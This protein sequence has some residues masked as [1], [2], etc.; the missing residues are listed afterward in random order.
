[1]ETNS[2]FIKAIRNQRLQPEETARLQADLD[3]LAIA[4]KDQKPPDATQ[5]SPV[6]S[7]IFVYSLAG[8]K[9]KNEVEQFI[10]W[11]SHPLEEPHWSQALDLLVNQLF[12]H[13][14]LGR[15]LPLLEKINE[16]KSLTHSEDPSDF[17]SSEQD[18]RLKG[19]YHNTVEHLNIDFSVSVLPFPLE[20]L[21]PRIVTVKPGKGNEL[22]RHA[23]E[24]VF[25]FLRG[26]GMVKVDHLSHPVGPGDFAFIPRW[27]LH[28]SINTGTEDLVFLAVADF[29]LTGKSFMGNYLKTA[30]MKHATEPEK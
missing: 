11:C 16:Q 1:M 15:V 14:Q 7:A 17:V 13:W 20:V 21:D 19:L 28:Q 26:K 30:R 2:L 3:Q 12:G 8:E 24:T 9:E 27:C 29:G 23:H 22:H 5:I 6:A 18:H 10:H 4:I 25:I